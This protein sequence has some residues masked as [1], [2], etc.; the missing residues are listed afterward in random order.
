MDFVLI[1]TTR[2]PSPFGRLCEFVQH[3]P[4]RSGALLEIEME[5]TR[6][7]CK[8]L[9]ALM[10]SSTLFALTVAVD[11]R[12]EDRSTYKARDL[13]LSDSV[14]IPGTCEREWSG[15]V[16]GVENEVDP[17]STSLPVDCRLSSDGSHPESM[18]LLK[19]SRPEERSLAVV[20][21]STVR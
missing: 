2:S 12:S 15:R 9:A 5:S 14:L 19:L 11:S 16:I 18:A 1:L 3:P 7:Y 4:S 10:G 13:W 21:K 6:A 8:Q 17:V 20:P